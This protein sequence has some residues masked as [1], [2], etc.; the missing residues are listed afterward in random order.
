[1]TIRSTKPK[2]GSVPKSRPSIPKTGRPVPPL[3]I[4]SGSVPELPARASRQEQILLSI[5]ELS[6]ATGVPSETIRIWERRYGKPDPLR[7]PSGHRRYDESHVHWLRRMAE[8][9][10]RGFRPSQVA[11]LSD[12]E[13]NRVLVPLADILKDPELA[14]LLTM[15]LEF[16][17][18]DLRAMLLEMGRRVPALTFLRDHVVP[19]VCSAS[20]WWADRRFAVRHEHLLSECLQDVLRALR[21]EAQPA[22]TERKLLL[23][24][25]PGDQHDLGLQMAAFLAAR[26]RIAVTLLGRD[27]PE[28]EFF[29]AVAETKPY[30][31]CISVSNLVG[32][33]QLERKLSELRSALPSQ[34]AMI[35]GGSSL[36]SF[37]RTIQG[38][39]HLATFE[40]LDHY[41]AMLAKD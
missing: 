14:A 35:V 18:T 7:L 28:S 12:A 31:V 36:R 20:C 17:D 9:V 29:N 27:L 8:A 24:T 21:M 11:R 10:S 23:T 40:D 38:I 39:D 19:L 6:E 41:L 22:I 3:V 4:P 13:L 1:M 5:G 16:R 33:S 37:K 25:L 32:T 30:G 26:H 15:I 2:P 34:I